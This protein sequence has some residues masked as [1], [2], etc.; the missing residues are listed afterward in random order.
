M[1]AACAAGHGL[2]GNQRYSAE[3]NVFFSL[4]SILAVNCQPSGGPHLRERPFC[5]L[6]FQPIVVA[7]GEALLQHSTIHPK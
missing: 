7:R 4:L 1:G 6:P 3:R 5:L 2:W